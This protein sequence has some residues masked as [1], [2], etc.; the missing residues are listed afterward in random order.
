MCTV[1]LR[2]YSNLSD[3]I[4]RLF[5][6]EVEAA[7]KMVGFFITFF[8]R[9]AFNFYRSYYEVAQELNE[10]DRLAFYDALLK[11]QFTGVETELIGMAKFAYLSQKHSIDQQIKGY[12]DKTKDPLV[13]PSVGGEQGGSVRPS[14]QEKEKEKEKEQNSIEARKSKFYDLLA[15]HIDKYP[16]EML[17]DFFDYWTE[18]GDLDKKMRFEK[19]NTF[20][21]KQRLATWHKRNPNQYKKESE[22]APEL[23]HL[24]NH[25]AKYGNQ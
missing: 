5:E 25:V 20:G 11:R 17:R 6:S 12:I 14:V 1:T 16:K 15:I 7:S 10:K 24:L 8:M 13:D 21:I 3:I 19:E 22:L 2:H 18:H 9:K 23:Q 4:T